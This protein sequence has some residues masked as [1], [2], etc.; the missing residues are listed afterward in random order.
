MI[1]RIL[2]LLRNHSLI[3][4]IGWVS[5]AKYPPTPPKTGSKKVPNMPPET[6]LCVAC[7]GAEHAKQFIR[8][9]KDQH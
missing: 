7:G 1:F 4:E 8:Q 2:F 5:K 3:K 6:V 9:N